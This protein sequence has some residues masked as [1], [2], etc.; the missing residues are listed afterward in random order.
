MLGAEGLNSEKEE[1]ILEEEARDGKTL[2]EAREGKEVSLLDR[3]CK[4]NVGGIDRYVVE[5]E[6]MEEGG[7]RWDKDG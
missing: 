1:N 3:K 2:E 5:G 4:W 7:N 6:V